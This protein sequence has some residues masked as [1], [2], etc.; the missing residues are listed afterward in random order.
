MEMLSDASSTLA[1]STM[2]IK[3]GSNRSPFFIFTDCRRE[4]NSLGHER[5]ERCRWHLE[6]RVVRAGRRG[7]RGGSMRAKAKHAV[8]SRHHQKMRELRGGRAQTKCSDRSAPPPPPFI[9]TKSDKLRKTMLRQALLARRGLYSLCQRL[10]LAS[11]YDKLKI[12]MN[13]TR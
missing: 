7:L 2:K 8:G 12:K 13:L 5:E 6:Q 4:A 9:I 10:K 11:V 3:M 1:T